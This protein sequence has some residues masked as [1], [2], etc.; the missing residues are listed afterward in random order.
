M[1]RYR[2]E[3][4]AAMLAYV[5][6]LM[7]SVWWLRSGTLDNPTARIAVALCPMIAGPFICWVVLR[8][9]R[10]VDELFR[11]VQL[12]ALAIAFAGTALITFSYGFLEGVGFPKLS[13]F[14]VWPV[15]AVLWILGSVFSA[16]RY[17]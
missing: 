12:E 15:M 9:L 1:N 11:R 3:M 13:L 17:R 16:R 4:T 5:V 14:V 7:A 2:K 10:R 8:Q 6:L